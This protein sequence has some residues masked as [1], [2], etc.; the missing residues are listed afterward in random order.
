MKTALKERGLSVSGVKADLQE[1]L[2]AALA[3]SATPATLEA[4][5]VEVTPE[6]TE[7]NQ[8]AEAE[9]LREIDAM[10]VEDL[11]KKELKTHLQH[12]NLS[13]AGKVSSENLSLWNLEQK[14][15]VKSQ[16]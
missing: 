11:T 14:S 15:E 4:P 12:R 8:A 1:R 10:D 16:Q 7:N 5:Q 2:S 13:T 9:E 3:S 6:N